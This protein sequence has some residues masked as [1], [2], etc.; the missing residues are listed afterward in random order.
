[1]PP[2]DLPSALLDV[3]RLRAQE[4]GAQALDPRDT[5]ATRLAPPVVDYR[6]LVYALGASSATVDR[7]CRPG[8]VPGDVRRIVDARRARDV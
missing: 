5:P 6:A 1:M 3:G 7:L 4:D 2:S 8:R